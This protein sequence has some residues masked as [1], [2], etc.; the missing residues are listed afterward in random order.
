L[1]KRR[2]EGANASPTKAASISSRPAAFKAVASC[3]SRLSSGGRRRRQTPEQLAR[4][5]VHGDAQPTLQSSARSQQG[6]EAGFIQGFQD[7]DLGAGEEGAH[8]LEGGILRGGADEGD[9]AGFDVGQEGVLLALVEAVH[10][11]DEQDGLAPRGLVHAR[12]FHRLADFLH[13]GQH[14]RDLDEIR[15]EVMGH[16]PGQGGFAHTGRAPQDHG[17]GLAGLEGETQGLAGAD[18]MRFDQ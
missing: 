6:G 3:S 7:I 10:F 16:E 9:Q 11:I 8:H 17:M 12:P 4:L 2:R 13:P 5:L 18:Q 1:S 14:R 15:V